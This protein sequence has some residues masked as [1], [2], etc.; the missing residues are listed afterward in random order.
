MIQFNFEKEPN[1]SAPHQHVATD[2]LANDQA[3]GRLGLHPLGA[4]HHQHHQ[5]DYLGEDH[6]GLELSDGDVPGPPL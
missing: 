3:L 2:Y 6:D 4:V 5:V 1:A